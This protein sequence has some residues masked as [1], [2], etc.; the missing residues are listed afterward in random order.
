[1]AFV[2][3]LRILQVFRI[4]AKTKHEWGENVEDK[5]G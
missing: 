1:V 3:I 5:G 2:N 4:L